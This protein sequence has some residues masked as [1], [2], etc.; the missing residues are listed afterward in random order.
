MR[1]GIGTG[2]LKTVVKRDCVL[3]FRR[4]GTWFDR[5]PIDG[6]QELW[7][8]LRS[9]GLRRDDNAGTLF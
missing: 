9:S 1:I 4:L 3:L 6:R 2:P 7:M 5:P 8:A